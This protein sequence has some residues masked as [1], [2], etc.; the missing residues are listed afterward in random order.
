[1]AYIRSLHFSVNKIYYLLTMISSKYSLADIA[2]PLARTAWPAPH[3]LAHP[4]S[5]SHISTGR[6][7]SHAAVTA[8]TPAATAAPRTRIMLAHPAWFAFAP[9]HPRPHPHLHAMPLAPSTLAFTHTPSLTSHTTLEPNLCSC[10]KKMIG[11]L[12]QA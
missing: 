8:R 11:S 7:H 2:R 12:D 3:M 1:V 4:H 5:H 10:H 9:A 6:Q